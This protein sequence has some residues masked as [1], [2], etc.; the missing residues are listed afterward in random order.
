MPSSFTPLF[1][2]APFLPPSLSICL[3]LSDSVTPPSPSLISCST[4]S[5]SGKMPDSQFSD[6]D[7][8]LCYFQTDHQVITLQPDL[9]DTKVNPAVCSSDE[10]KQRLMLS[11]RESARRSRWRKQK[12]SEYVSKE[13]NR[14]VAQ[15]L[16]YKNRLASVMRLRHLLQRDNERLMYEYLAFKA[17][18]DDLYGISVTMQLA[19]SNNFS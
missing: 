7:E 12:H 3:P 17:K 10:R 16:E 5:I 11:N 9:E 15:N 6:I 1:S 19:S 14:L 2:L 8:V 13:L 18:L 4:H